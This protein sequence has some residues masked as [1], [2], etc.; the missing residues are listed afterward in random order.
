MKAEKN[1]RLLDRF[2]KENQFDK[3]FIFL[4][5]DRTILAEVAAG[6]NH[7]DTITSDEID[8]PW[9]TA[10]RNLQRS[11]KSIKSRKS[12]SPLGNSKRSDKSRSSISSSNLKN[13]KSSLAS[14]DSKSTLKSK[15]SNK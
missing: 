5:S 6:Y 3:D 9:K 14:R 15:Q 11:E 8:V 4:H 7:K 10:K 12:I 2:I 1:L 13:S